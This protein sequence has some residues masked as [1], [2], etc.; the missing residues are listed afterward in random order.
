M[1]ID[2]GDAGFGGGTFLVMMKLV[3]IANEPE[4][5]RAKPIYLSSTIRW[6]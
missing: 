6:S 3:P 5:A 1:E 2:R 4:T